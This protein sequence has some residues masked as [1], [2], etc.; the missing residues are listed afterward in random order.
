MLEPRPAGALDDP[1]VPRSLRLAAALA[2]RFLV[3]GLAVVAL[4]YVLSAIRVIVV[5]VVIAIVFSTLLMPI[6]TGLMRS[7][8]PR[9][10]ASALALLLTLLVL[11][12]TVTALVPQVADEVG[13]LDVSVTDGIAKVTG[14]LSTGPFGLSGDVVASWREQA[15]EQLRGQSGALLGGVFGGAY[16]ALEIVVGLALGIVALFFFLKDGERIWAWATRLFPPQAQVHVSRIGELAWRTIG[17]YLR[18]VIVVAAVDAIFIG[19]ALWALG[20]PLVVPLA[21]LTFL[22]GFFPIVGAFTAGFAAVMVALV[23]NGPTTALLV[24]GAVL[25]VQQIESNLLQPVVVGNATKVH[26]LAVLLAVATGG[27]VW[28]VAGAFLAVPVAAVINQAGT[29]LAS[30]RPRVTLPATVDQPGG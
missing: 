9:G 11:G 25:L 30:E 4:A 23:A 17:G 29:Y 28:G 27:V 2:W 13:E 21:L 12:G 15:L 1:R 20:V 14:W 18:G 16:L 19:L 6:V 7:G 22:G 3:I 10:L 24:F 8:A 5:P 26:P